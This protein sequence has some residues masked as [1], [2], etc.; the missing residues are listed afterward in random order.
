VADPIDVSTSA[1][2][3]MTSTASAAMPV[4]VNFKVPS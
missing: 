2:A 4:R 1:V 3:A